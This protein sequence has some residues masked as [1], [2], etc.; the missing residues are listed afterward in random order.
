MMCLGKNNDDSSFGHS[1][2]DISNNDDYHCNYDYCDN[3]DSTTGGRDWLFGTSVVS[4]ENEDHD[5]WF[6]DCN[7]V[8]VLWFV[9]PLVVTACFGM[10]FW[11]NHAQ[12]LN[13]LRVSNSIVLFVIVGWLYRRSCCRQIS[14]SSF[15]LL[16]PELIMSTVLGFLF[17]NK[18]VEAYL[19]L[20]IGTLFLATVVMIINIKLMMW[21]MSLNSERVESVEDV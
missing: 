3:R 21:N 11:S 5:S 4:D 13:F 10:A 6:S 1:V 8:V 20:L 16:L 2:T 7:H 15:V 19:V 14:K 18:L 12:G 9:F 17:L